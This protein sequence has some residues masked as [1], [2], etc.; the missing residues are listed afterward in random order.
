M[1]TH[2]TF[3]NNVFETKTPQEN[4]I[5]PCCFGEDCANW[6]ADRLKE[7]GLAVD[8]VIQE[9]WGWIF[10]VTVAGYDFWLGVSSLEDEENRWLLFCESRLSLFKKMIG[11]SD[12]ETQRQVCSTVDE[13]LKGTPHISEVQWFSKENGMSGGMLWSQTPT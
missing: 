12:E 5:N 9:D 13:I 7:K 10:A 8:E 4:F 3:T 11:K 1:K 2:V 6:L